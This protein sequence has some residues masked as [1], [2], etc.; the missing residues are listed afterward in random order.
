MF[1]NFK[2]KRALENDTMDKILQKLS[3]TP[4][5]YNTGTNYKHLDS[6]LVIKYGFDFDDAR[7]ISEPVYHNIPYRY[8]K[9][10]NKTIE[11][12]IVK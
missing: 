11:K 3:N 4:R 5:W 12:I 9:S 1:E 8:K 10:F 6:D 2:K 7:C